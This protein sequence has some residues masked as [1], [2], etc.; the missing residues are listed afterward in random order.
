MGARGPKPRDRK[1]ERQRSHAHYDAWRPERARVFMGGLTEAERA[2][3]IL[4]FGNDPAGVDTFLA[5]RVQR[6]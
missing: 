6:G 2:A 1:G 4:L 3:L 5:V